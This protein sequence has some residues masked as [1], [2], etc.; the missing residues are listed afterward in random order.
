MLNAHDGG[1]AR[2][3]HEFHSYDDRQFTAHR[4]PQIVSVPPSAPQLSRS[5]A[6]RSHRQILA[7]RRSATN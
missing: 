3:R 2:S 5:S 4:S 7:V 6:R 1:R